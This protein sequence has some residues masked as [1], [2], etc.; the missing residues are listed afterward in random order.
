MTPIGYWRSNTLADILGTAHLPD[1]RNQV[2]RSW[3]ATERARVVAYLKAGQVHESWFG[4][5]RCRLCLCPNGSTDRTD[6]VYVWPDGYAHYVED[7]AVK[8]PDEFVQY[9]L[10]RPG[11]VSARR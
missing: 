6:G 11:A 4:F 1:P 9:V 8:P 5:S 3:N 7:H 2:D 10:N